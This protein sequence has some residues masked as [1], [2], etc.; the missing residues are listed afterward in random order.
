MWWCVCVAFN[1]CVN[2]FVCTVCTHDIILLVNTLYIVFTCMYMCVHV[3]TCVYM[4]VH[5]CACVYMCVHVCICVYMY[6]HVCACVYMC[7]YVCTCVCMCVHVCTCVYMC[8][9]CFF[10][11]ENARVDAS[12]CHADAGEVCYSQQEQTWQPSGGVSVGALH[13]GSEGGHRDRAAGQ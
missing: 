5:V 8:T 1:V 4:Y 12:C 7:V 11:C 10:L 13:C 9:M 3:C 6:V 2:T